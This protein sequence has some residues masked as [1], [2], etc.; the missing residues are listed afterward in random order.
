MV[1]AAR[2][3]LGGPADFLDKAETYLERT[4]I[5]RAV[6]PDR[7]G[8]V[9]SIDTRAVGIAVLEM[10]G[11]RSKPTDAIDHAV[12]FSR[13]AGDGSAVGGADA[14]LGLVHARNEAM[15]DKAAASLKAAYRVGSYSAI[16]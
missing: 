2:G 15:A 13:L 1:A 7:P 11:G 4:P 3:G 14:P 12:G 6:M 16:A 8:I 5:I 10:G 9:Q